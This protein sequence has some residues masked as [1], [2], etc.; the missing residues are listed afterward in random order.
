MPRITSYQ[1]NFQKIDTINC[2]QE[3]L[4]LLH[5]AVGV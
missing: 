5:T 4:E 1:E 3:Q 2:W